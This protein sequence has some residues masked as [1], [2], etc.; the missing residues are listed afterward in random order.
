LHHLPSAELLVG[1][2]H[3]LQHDPPRDAIHHQMMDDHQQARRLVRTTIEDSDAYKWTLDE[4]Q[5][6]LKLCGC[7]RNL[8]AL[9]LF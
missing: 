7:L 1:H 4:V 2:L 9:L 3:V 5:A 8:H 6:G